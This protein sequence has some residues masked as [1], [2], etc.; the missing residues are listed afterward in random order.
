MI[1]NELRKMRRD[2]YTEVVL[3]DLDGTLA[4]TTHRHSLA[5]T[6]TN[7]S[8]WS[9]YA[10]ACTGDIP[11]FDLLQLLD[12]LS[13][14]YLVHLISG[15]DGSALRETKE[16]LFAYDVPYDSVTLRPEDDETYNADLKVRYIR[17]LRE[18]GL[19]PFILFDDW[20][21]TIEAVRREG[22]FVVEVKIP[23]A[24]LEPS[25]EAGYVGLES[26]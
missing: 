12:V 26:V 15:R 19:K 3:C 1:S 22:V 14:R 5:P 23:D 6:A 10:K 25:G 8:T 20:K 11:N 7:G 9:A 24:P 2:F 16:W 21:P 4:D 13:R 18:K 17:Q